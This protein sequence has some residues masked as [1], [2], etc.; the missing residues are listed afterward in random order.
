MAALLL[1]VHYSSVVLEAASF[2][3]HCSPAF[4]RQYEIQGVCSSTGH[5]T[6]VALIK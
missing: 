6:A 2:L 3:Y 4:T 5:A 1:R